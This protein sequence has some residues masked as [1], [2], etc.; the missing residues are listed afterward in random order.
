MIRASKRKPETFKQR[1]HAETYY[2]V[3]DKTKQVI[4]GPQ[5]VKE[6]LYDEDP[7]KA[8][9]Q[10][11]STRL[12]TVPTGTTILQALAPSARSGSGKA[13]ARPDKWYVVRDNV[14]L[15]GSDIRNPVQSQD[16]IGQPAV[17]F[18]FSSEGKKI[19]ERSRARSRSAARSRPSAAPAISTSPSH[20]TTSCSPCPS[21]RRR[22]PG[23]HL[24][25]HRRADL[26]QPDDR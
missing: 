20:S 23:R 6:D 22:V 19:W 14:A 11:K 3:N 12:V 17:S 7:A 26:G 10:K 5:T 4:A 8:A 9:E 13:N 25:R 15:Q 1:A 16:S 18:D 21:L 2:L 24:G